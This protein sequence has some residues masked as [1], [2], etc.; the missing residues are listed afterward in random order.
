MTC[1]EKSIQR[2]LT[3]LL[4]KL[5]QR[6]FVKI[7]LQNESLIDNTKNDRQDAPGLY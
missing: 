2:L 5:L 4:Q 6:L 1:Q 3:G 7:R